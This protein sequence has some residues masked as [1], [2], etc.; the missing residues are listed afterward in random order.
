M[1]LLTGE[2]RKILDKP[3]TTKSGKS[4]SQAVLVLEPFDS[5]QNFEVYLSAKQLAGGVREQWEKLKGQQAAIM[6]QLF[7]NFDYKFYKY[8]AIGEAKPIAAPTF[9]I[10]S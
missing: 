5:S 2:V 6:C 10:L 7:I 8:N 9:E 1:I 3:Y 4:V